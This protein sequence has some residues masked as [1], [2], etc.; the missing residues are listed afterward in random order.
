[1][2]SNEM[3]LNKALVKLTVSF[4]FI[5]MIGITKYKNRENINSRG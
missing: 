2:P 4:L 3:S 5:I 1:M